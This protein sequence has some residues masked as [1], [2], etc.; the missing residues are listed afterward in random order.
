MHVLSR[1]NGDCLATISQFRRIHFFIAHEVNIAS[2]HGFELVYHSSANDSVEK[3]PGVP[4][5]AL[6]K[7]QLAASFF[8]P[9]PLLPFRQRNNRELRPLPA[10]SDLIQRENPQLPTTFHY[11]I[12]CATMCYSP[13]FCL[14]RVNDELHFPHISPSFFVI[15]RAVFHREFNKTCL[16]SIQIQNIYMYLI[17]AY[18]YQMKCLFKTDSIHSF[19]LLENKRY[20]K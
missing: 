9:R 18:F 7:P 15:I 2:R 11:V 20:Q 3:W 17:K 14:E 19:V 12:L 13:Q 10:V 6:F 8:L 5:L 4:H 16:S 1:R